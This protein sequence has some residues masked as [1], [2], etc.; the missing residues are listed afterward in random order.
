MP[1]YQTAGRVAR[2]AL[3][4]IGAFPSSRSAP[5]PGEY[6]T[7]LEW[8]EMVLNTTSGIRPLAGFYRLVDIPLESGVGD[9]LLSDFDDSARTAHVFSVSLINGT[10]DPLPLKMLWESE[11][12][13][14]N[15]NDTGESRRVVITKDRDP[16][17][18]V[19]PTPTS[20]QEDAGQLLRL[21]I[22]TWHDEIDVDGI[23][24]SDL[25]LRPAW[26]LWL[27]KRT[28]YEIGCGPVRRL[29]EGELKRLQ[30]DSEKLEM[31]L[32]ARDGKN[33]GPY[34]PVTEPM[35]GSYNLD[36]TATY[37]KDTGYS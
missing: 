8:L 23:A 28:A 14:E 12:A 30:D 31:Q 33:N 24:D 26:Y 5:D 27:T 13:D 37:H 21:R 20:T 3:K 16:T 17:L 36:Y 34:P 11:S 18:K 9:Y 19:Y 29:G 25:L 10:A 4:T 32:L 22:Q 2:N 1:T 7:A 35:D 6:S 15:L